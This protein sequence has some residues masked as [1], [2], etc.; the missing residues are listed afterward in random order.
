MALSQLNS[1]TFGEAGASVCRTHTHVHCF[2]HLRTREDGGN[3]TLNF[4][5]RR[6][7]YCDPN[8]AGIHTEGQH[9]SAAPSGTSPGTIVPTRI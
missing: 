5:L 6:P 2:D 1:G 9:N 4:R 7:I 8:S 3:D